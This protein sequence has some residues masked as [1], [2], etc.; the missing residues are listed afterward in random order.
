M[1]DLNDWVDVPSPTPEVD[2]W[3]DVP[4]EKN[5]T[6][7]KT[8]VG[9]ALLSG[10][11]QIL[12]LGDEAAGLGGGIATALRGGKFTAGYLR[13]RNA[14]RARMEAA[15]SE[16]PAAYYGPMVGGAI[17]T[18]FTP[19]GIASRATQ[20]AGA[21]AKIGTAAGVNGAMGAFQG[22]TLSE[23]ETAGG[24]VKDSL[25]GGG[26][27]AAFG[28]A[29]EALGQGA[30]KVGQYLN[31]LRGKNLDDALSPI[32]HDTSVE[33]AEMK[34][35]RDTRD[36][37]ASG[38]PGPIPVHKQRYAEG[39]AKLAQAPAT[40]EGLAE[41]AA[42]LEAVTRAHNPTIA[43]SVKHFGRETAQSL[44]GTAVGYNIGDT[45]G[46]NVGAMVGAGLGGRLGATN[47]SPGKLSLGAK[48]ADMAGGAARQSTGPLPT[49]FLISAYLDAQ[50]GNDEETVP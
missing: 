39:M 32:A 33:R 41:K 26:I 28:A 49:R 11:G 47:M 17:A 25:V 42:R 48:L 4:V 44:I 35:V 30:N 1:A 40:A 10:T 5:I 23:A 13:E 7:P 24:V 38:G 8:S 37:L 19:T 31:K 14:E 9:D 43:E 18:S 34:W 15:G 36:R 2:D 12:G 20:G 29:G 46:G 50:R 22:A 16:H 6:G 27:G 3:Q 21:L 45:V